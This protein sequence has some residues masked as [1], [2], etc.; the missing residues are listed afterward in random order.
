MSYRFSLCTS[1]PRS[2]DCGAAMLETALLLPVL[3][4]II[5]GLIY[6]GNQLQSHSLLTNVAQEGARFMARRP[7]L[8]TV[9]ETI[10]FP[11]IKADPV[12]C[13]EFPAGSICSA[14]A[15]HQHIL[16]L[17]RAMNLRNK[18]FALTN[19]RVVTQFIDAEDRVEVVLSGETEPSS[20]FTPVFINLRTI[21]SEAS[22]PYLANR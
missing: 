1:V 4:I 11:E 20:A 2:S 16:K 18:K 3:F 19:I 14:T 9:P 5:S 8:P 15:T 7:G 6:A 12:C 22:Q 21:R 13:P 17:L 10:C